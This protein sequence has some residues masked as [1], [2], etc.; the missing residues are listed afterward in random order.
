MSDDSP[1]LE[2]YATRA[3]FLAGE[4]S[5]TWENVMAE[6]PGV[7]AAIKRDYPER[8]EALEQAD[9]RWKRAGRPAGMLRTSA[10]ATVPTPRPDPQPV[11]VTVPD[12]AEIKSV[13]DLLSRGPVALHAFK[14][15]YPAEFA[16]LPTSTPRQ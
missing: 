9:A 14:Q 8:A 10:P 1:T 13:R 4:P 2:T 3:A 15:T 11:P 5:A 6:G 16:A 7:F 12:P